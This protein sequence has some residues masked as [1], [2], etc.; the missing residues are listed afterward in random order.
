MDTQTEQ[1]PT[2][3]KFHLIDPKFRHNVGSYIFQCSLA[4][5]TF[6]IILLFLDIITHTAIVACLG[7]S[8]FIVFTLPRYYTSQ[9]R[10]LVGG[11]IVG[12]TV[13]CLCYYLS[14]APFLAPLLP[15]ERTSYIIFGALAVGVAILVMT[16]TNTEHPPATGIALGLVLN[17]WDYRTIIF[18]MLAV[19]LM[20]AVRELVKARMINLM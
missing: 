6:I 8:A 20:A 16:V 15:G 9:L 3:K 17:S 4:A 14:C 7:A 11:Y 1:K 2:E 13:G 12:I 19:F 18:V 5:G 10:P